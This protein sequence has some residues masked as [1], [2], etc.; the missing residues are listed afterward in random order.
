MGVFL[1]KNAATPYVDH[2]AVAYRAIWGYGS[3]PPPTLPI[4]LRMMEKFD[5][6]ERIRE[7]PA[8]AN[9]VPEK[10]LPAQRSHCSPSLLLQR[11]LAR[12]Y[13]VERVS[14][15]GEDTAPMSAPDGDSDTI[16]TMPHGQTIERSCSPFVWSLRRWRH[17]L[18]CTTAL[19]LAIRASQEQ[20]WPAT[21]LR[22]RSHGSW[23]GQ[24]T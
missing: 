18:T 1:P 9:R 2:V 11:E 19:I 16:L 24:S 7:T 21:G 17:Q 23:I 10:L 8:P 4:P 3:M 13:L 14:L 15:P 5:L 20:R 12:Q 22:R 6:S